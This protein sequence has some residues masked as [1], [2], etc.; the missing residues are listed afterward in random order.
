MLRISAQSAVISDWRPKMLT[1]TS[2][3]NMTGGNVILRSKRTNPSINVRSTLQSK[4]KQQTYYTNLT[5][6]NE[7]GFAQQP[8]I[9]IRNQTRLNL[10]DK[11]HGYLY[12]DEQSRTTQNKRNSDFTD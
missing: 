2:S 9:L 4:S 5:S 11:I 7:S 3:L 10:P 6:F 1:R 8:F 12:H